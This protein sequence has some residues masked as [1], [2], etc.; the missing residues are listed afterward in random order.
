MISIIIPCYNEEKYIGKTLAY[1]KKLTLPHEITI[2]DDKST[3]GTVE[4]VRK[5][6]V[7]ILTTETKFPTIAAN[8]NNGAKHA[9]GDM[10][11]FL[12]CDTHIENPDEF[13]SAALKE[14]SEKKK[15]VALT[16]ALWV[17]PDYETTADRIVYFIFNIVHVIK[18]N[19]LNTGEASG[20][21]QMMR[22]E[23]FEKVGGFREDLVTREDADMFQRLAKIGKTECDLGLEI[24]HTGRRSRALGWPKLLWIWMSES[25]KFAFIKKSSI[26]VWTEVR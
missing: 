7:Q 13:F 3:D 20:K 22:R 8:R 23:A 2:T 19:I 5:A 14:F 21:F 15:L 26:E 11:V 17:L 1:L 6:G 12:D 10:L 16:G 25:F 4:I 9:K 18:N 24:Y